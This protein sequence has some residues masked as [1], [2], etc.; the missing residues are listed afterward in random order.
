M[1]DLSL[2][3]FPSRDASVDAASSL[4]SSANT[5]SLP[6]FRGAFLRSY[7]SPSRASGDTFI[8]GDVV[9]VDVEGWDNGDDGD[10][11]DGG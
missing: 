4:R 2:R 5:P 3:L 6:S 8:V 7:I 10:D 9:V 11:D 1:D